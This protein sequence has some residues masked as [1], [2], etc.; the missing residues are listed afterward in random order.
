MIDAVTKLSFSIVPF[1]DEHLDGA[2]T[3]LAERHRAQRL[4]EP[5]VFQSAA[6][7]RQP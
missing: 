7:V 4:V 2:A 1:A 6:A 5:G 3:L